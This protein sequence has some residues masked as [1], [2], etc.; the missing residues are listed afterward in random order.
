MKRMVQTCSTT[1][2]S[3]K[4]IQAKTLFWFGWLVG[5]DLHCI[6]FPFKQVANVIFPDSP[7]GAGFSYS[8]NPKGYNIDDITAGIEA[9]QKTLLNFKGYVIGNPGTG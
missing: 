2:L 6:L 5:Q 1:L 8:S 4:G 9:G 3:R 7:I